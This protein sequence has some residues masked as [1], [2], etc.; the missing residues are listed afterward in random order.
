MIELVR[1][2]NDVEDVTEGLFLVLT[3]MSLCLKCFNILVRQCELRSLLDCFR[4]KLCQPKDS[5]EKSILRRYDL[6]GIFI[7][8]K[9]NIK[10]LRN[11]REFHIWNIKY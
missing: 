10:K 11:I 1:I 9:R 8:S 2:R 5:T 4:A 7:I 3:Y 6:K